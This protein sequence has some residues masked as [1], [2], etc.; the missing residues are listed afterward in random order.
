MKWILLLVFAY[1]LG[2][3]PTGVVVARLFGAQDPRKAGSGNIGATNVARTLGK[4]P[5]I[6]TLAG[7]A[8]KGFIPA[9]WAASAFESAPAM[10]LVGLAAFAGHLWPVFLGFK[11]GKGVATAL[12]VF[13]ALAT[14]PVILA[15]GVFGA[16]VWQWRMVSLGSISAAVAMPILCGLLGRPPAVTLLALVIAGLTVWKHWENIERIA[17]G[18]ENQ[19]D[20]LR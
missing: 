17:S 4:L 9:V 6:L 1:L 18:T 3:I 7:D 2:S 20:A 10:A 8:L 19:I 14:G 13:L 11:G 16:V 15:A 12:G 5:G